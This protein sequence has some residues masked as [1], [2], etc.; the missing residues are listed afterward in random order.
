MRGWHG[1]CKS[2]SAGNRA[3]SPVSAE[4]PQKMMTGRQNQIPN[5]RWL[6]AIAMC[7]SLLSGILV[8]QS[9]NA[10]N[11]VNRET[12]S[13]KTALA[14]YATDM[15]AAAERGRFNSIEARRELTDRA[16]QILASEQKN[17]PVVISESQ[18]VRDL[19]VIGVAQRMVAGD[20]PETL[21]GKRLFKLNLEKLFHDS[22]NAAELKTNLSAILSDV[23][24]S[25]AKV[26]LIIDPVQSLIGSAGAFDG[27]ASELLLDAIKKGDVQCFGATT[28]VAYQQD[29]A[30]EQSLASLFTAID[31]QEAT[32]ADDQADENSSAPSTLEPFVGDNISPDMRELASSSNAPARVKAILQVNNTNSEK[33]RESLAKYGARIEGEMPRF[34]ALAVDLP[35]SAIEKIANGKNAKYLSLDRRGGGRGHVA[36]Q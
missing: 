13:P 24:K 16:L 33:V 35:T 15:T 23:A 1:R 18:A 34:G 8:S 31:T 5:W 6:I 36:G 17:N 14:I 26:I 28:D 2:D 25:E 9:A 12:A 11:V 29:V 7:V 20:L 4:V 27:T 10:Q 21:A 3:V 19:V 32:K 30:Q 22:S